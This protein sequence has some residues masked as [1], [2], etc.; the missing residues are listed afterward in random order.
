MTTNIRELIDESKLTGVQIT[1][2]VVC[3]FLNMLDGMDVLAISFAAPAI[4]NEWAI[5]P[6]SLGIVSVSYTHLTLPTIYSV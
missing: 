6:E 1:V 2:L 5:T 4:T 3:F